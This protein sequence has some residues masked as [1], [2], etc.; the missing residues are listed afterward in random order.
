[1][2][3]SGGRNEPQAMNGGGV[4]GPDAPPPP[5]GGEGGGGDGGGEGGGTGGGEGGGGDGGG[6]DGAS[7]A[8]DCSATPFFASTVTPRDAER[9]TSDMA[10][11]SAVAASA[12]AA[13]GISISDRTRTLP[14]D[15][16]S[17]TCAGATPSN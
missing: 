7:L 9:S 17:C 2:S 15:R 4:E 3:A 6:G 12:A 8:T 11:K 5:S 16:L 13:L 1:M 14:A 10:C